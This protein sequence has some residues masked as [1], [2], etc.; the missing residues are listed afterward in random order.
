MQRAYIKRSYFHKVFCDQCQTNMI[1]FTDDGHFWKSIFNGMNGAIF[2][3]WHQFQCTS[4]GHSMVKMGC[5]SICF[6]ILSL[7]NRFHNIVRILYCTHPELNKHNWK[8]RGHTNKHG[9]TDTLYAHLR[10]I[11]AQTQFE[12]DFE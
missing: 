2:R 11:K 10:K 12:Q 4:G 9:H 6:S 7:Q 5:E 8:Q 1:V 3:K